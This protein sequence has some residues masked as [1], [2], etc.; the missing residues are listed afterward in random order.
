MQTIRAIKYEQHRCIRQRSVYE[1][2]GVIHASCYNF[3][4]DNNLH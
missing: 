3:S 4:S 1:I 2:S